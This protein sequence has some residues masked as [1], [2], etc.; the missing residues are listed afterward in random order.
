MRYAEW[1]DLMRGR[2]PVRI[3]GRR[4]PTGPAPRGRVFEVLD[5]HARTLWGKSWSK[6]DGQCK[7][8]AL[9]WYNDRVER[10]SPRLK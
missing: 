5:Q 1:V 2:D 9:R 10:P 6:L 7:E 4:P 8:E 3:R